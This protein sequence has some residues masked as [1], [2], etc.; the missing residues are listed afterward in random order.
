MEIKI[1]LSCLL[2]YKELTP[3][4]GNA[5]ALAS[6]R[7]EGTHLTPLRTATQTPQK[8]PSRHN[9]V[10]PL[11]PSLHIPQ[12]AQKSPEPFSDLTTTHT[13][14]GTRT[15]PWGGLPARAPRAQSG[16]L[17]TP[18]GTALPSHTGGRQEVRAHVPDA[19]PLSSLESALPSLHNSWPPTQSPACPAS[20]T[21]AG[22][23]KQTCPG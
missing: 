19:G 21:L 20:C 13:R 5:I 15:E 18:R 1:P 23:R 22:V 16:P 12:L 10:A 3:P 2:F 4:S 6:A 9:C 17:P 14:H 7:A 11:P 8:A